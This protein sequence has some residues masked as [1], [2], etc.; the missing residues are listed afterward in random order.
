MES[1]FFL[2]FSVVIK[3]A[4][5][6]FPSPVLRFER[7]LTLPSLPDMVFD[8]N[9]L[10][11]SHRSGGSISFNSLDALKCVN[12]REDSL[13]VAHAEVWKEARLESSACCIAKFSHFFMS[14][15]TFVPYKHRRPVIFF[16][17]IF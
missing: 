16:P 12:D 13:Q 1:L 11:I 15:F 3:A 5:T 4:Q 10:S 7:E 14:T 2:K 6:H 9:L 17:F 8:N